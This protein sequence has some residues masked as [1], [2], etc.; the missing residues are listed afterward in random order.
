MTDL[1]NKEIPLDQEERDLE[2]AL[3]TLDLGTIEKP[4]EARQLA[5]KKAA[6]N[7]SKNAKM[8]IR[9]NEA[10]LEAIKQKAAEE[11]LK[12]QPFVR[13]VL[14]KYVTG[15]LVEKTGMPNHRW[16]KNRP[17]WDTVG[18]DPSQ[19]TRSNHKITVG[20]SASRTIGS[21]HPRT[22]RPSVKHSG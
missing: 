16:M 20:G 9:I 15:Q 18:N 8:N 22:K 1:K 4:S 11:G 21:N 10:E 14:H 13:S 6:A 7:F 12:Y 5:L 3:N 17:G 2:E 19:A